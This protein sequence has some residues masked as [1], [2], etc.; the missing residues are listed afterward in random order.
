MQVGSRQLSVSVG[1]RVAGRQSPVRVAG[2]PS[3]V[4]DDMLAVA[5]PLEGK[6]PP[7]DTDDVDQESASSTFVHVLSL[8]PVS[9]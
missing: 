6:A 8:S 4:P 1:F 5:C 9:L 7:E 3:R 2:R